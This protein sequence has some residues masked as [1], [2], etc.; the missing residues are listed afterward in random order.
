VA[1]LCRVYMG[2]RGLSEE[3]AAGHLALAG[4]PGLV[5]DFP[6]CFTWSNFSPTVLAARAVT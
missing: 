5:R 3:V 6:A 1:A 2:R 4:D